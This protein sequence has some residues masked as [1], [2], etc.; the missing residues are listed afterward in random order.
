VV[1]GSLLFCGCAANQKRI[2]RAMQTPGPPPPAAAVEPYTLGCPDVIEVRFQ[3]QTGSPIPCAVGVDGRI[4]LG[5]RSRVRVEGQTQ[6]QASRTI[7]A[8]A[9]LPP[10]RVRVSVRDYKSRQIYLSGEVAGLHRTVPYQGP[11]TVADLLRRV[12]GVTSGAATGDVHVIRSHIIDGQA[13]EDFHVD[14]RAIYLDHDDRTNL[15]LQPFDQVYVG[16]TRKSSLTKCFP[17]WLR[18]AYEKLFGL[19]RNDP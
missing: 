5:D 15:I 3:G 11:E 14:L 16:E 6:A 9:G 10:D 1:V 7:A 4:E 18:P 2:G 19:K 8:A 13:P 17:R 12:G